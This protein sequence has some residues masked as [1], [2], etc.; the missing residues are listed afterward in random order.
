MD[1]G[2]VKTNINNTHIILSSSGIKCSNWGQ[3][4]PRTREV[5]VAQ[6][7]RVCDSKRV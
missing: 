5:P 4:L 7:A 3:L 6:S 1:M 2:Q